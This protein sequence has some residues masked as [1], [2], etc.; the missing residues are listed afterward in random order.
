MKRFPEVEYLQA[1]PGKIDERSTPNR[2][3]PVYL[4][5]PCRGSI[6]ADVMTVAMLT[7]ATSKDRLD[8]NLPVRP[9]KE[10]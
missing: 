5:S 7:V 6:I 2:R 3:W 1:V 10:W 9:A 8:S 4:R